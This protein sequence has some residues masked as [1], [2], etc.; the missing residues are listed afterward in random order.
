MDREGNGILVRTERLAAVEAVDFRSFTFDMF[1]HMCILSGCDY[2][3]NINGMGLK[4]AH[5]MMKKYRTV[6]KVAKIL[7]MKLDLI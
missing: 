6:E 1:R 5:K 3:E 2:L 4:T 7:N